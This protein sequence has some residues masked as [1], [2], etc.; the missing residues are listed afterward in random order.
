M[1]QNEGEKAANRECKESLRKLYKNRHRLYSIFSKS[2]IYLD[3][4][5]GSNDL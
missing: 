2:F 4:Q 5:K 1:G 3:H